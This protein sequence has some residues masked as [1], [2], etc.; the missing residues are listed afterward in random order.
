MGLDNNTL[1][2]TGP[3]AP[4]EISEAERGIASTD[5]NNVVQR[6]IAGSQFLDKGFLTTQELLESHDP[7]AF[8]K[9]S[10]WAKERQASRVER[11]KTGLTLTQSSLNARQRQG[12]IDSNNAWQEEA[13]EFNKRAIDENWTLEDRQNYATGRD[14]GNPLIRDDLLKRLDY[15]TKERQWRAGERKEGIAESTEEV[16]ARAAIIKAETAAKEAMI[17]HDD[18]LDAEYGDRRTLIGNLHSAGFDRETAFAV[19]RWSEKSEENHRELK[20]LLAMS[21]SITEA[22][23]MGLGVSLEVEDA[24]GGRATML[25]KDRGLINKALN[26]IAKDG[27]VSQDTELD[28]IM[29]QKSARKVVGERK[30]KISRIDAQIDRYKSIMGVVK[31]MSNPDKF[32]VLDEHAKILHTRFLIAQAA[33]NDA[34]EN[35]K[36]KKVTKPL[37]E[38]MKSSMA[39]YEDALILKGSKLMKTDPKDPKKMVL[40]A[41]ALMT[42]NNKFEARLQGELIRLQ[43]EA[44][45]L[46]GGGHG[47]T[48]PEVPPVT[49]DGKDGDIRKFGSWKEVREAVG[50]TSFVEEGKIIEVSGELFAYNRDAKSFTEYDPDTETDAETDTGADT[51][52]LEL[53]DNDEIFNVATGGDTFVGVGSKKKPLNNGVIPEAAPA[54]VEGAVPPAEGEVSAEVKRDGSPPEHILD[55]LRSKAPVAPVAPP[56]EYGSTDVSGLPVEPPKIRLKAPVTPPVAPSANL[57]ALR[58][59]APGPDRVPT[60][61]ASVSSQ[62]LSTDSEPPD[63]SPIFAKLPVEDKVR[64]LTVNSNPQYAGAVKALREVAK[65]ADRAVAPEERSVELVEPVSVVPVKPD[66]AAVY[67]KENL[68]HPLTKAASK[69]LGQQEG[70]AENPNEKLEPIFRALHRRAGTSGAQDKSPWCAAFV[71]QTLKDAGV[72]LPFYVSARKYLSVGTKVTEGQEKEGDVAVMWNNEE[73]T[74]GPSG[75]GGHAAFI[76]KQTEKSVFVISGNDQDGVRINEF[77]RR[78]LLGVRRLKA[79]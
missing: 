66:N 2:F 20:G 6:A 58:S 34:Y 41:E 68:R 50:R 65:G 47:G 69:Y 44:I 64:K 48:L 19:G 5:P 10:A 35:G 62:P 42:F 49:G 38:E 4:V 40:D 7:A 8:Q 70:T 31:S 55:A 13:E 74:G 30:N 17:K 56:L 76:I 54:Y 14:R 60:V 36:N 63:A 27:K 26:E 39:A 61:D 25:L 24:T 23:A 53:N 16:N 18:L 11:A 3:N 78:R 32:Q 37:E 1:S 46:G 51:E 72:K 77:D 22:Q 57:S 67:A 79:N 59:V 71:S 45:S 15:N 9:A 29:A 21:R 28:L 12:N 73:T 33:Y 75:W 52:G 43:Q